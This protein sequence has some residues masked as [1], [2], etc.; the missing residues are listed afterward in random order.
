LEII[1]G[2]VFGLR[3]W[4]FRLPR[5]MQFLG[6]KFRHCSSRRWRISRK[7]LTGVEW[8]NSFPENTPEEKEGE[9]D[10]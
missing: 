10:L 6:N 2:T 5:P 9:A 8:M 1:P 7:Q 3:P 4:D